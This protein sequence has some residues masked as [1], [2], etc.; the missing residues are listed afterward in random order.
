MVDGSFFMAGS[1]G[2]MVC[3]L[4]LCVLL[5]VA[6]LVQEGDATMLLYIPPFGPKLFLHFH[7]VTFS[8]FH[9]CIS[10][11]SRL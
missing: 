7:I 3:C 9:I 11:I 1:L 2:F 5:Q 4:W 10:F 6:F 8:N